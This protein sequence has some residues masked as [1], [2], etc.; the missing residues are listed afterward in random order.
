MLLNVCT[1]GVQ[2]VNKSKAIIIKPLF[3]KTETERPHQSRTHVRERIDQ[4]TMTFAATIPTETTQRTRRRA[5]SLHGAPL[6]KMSLHGVSAMAVAAAMLFGVANTAHAQEEDSKPATPKLTDAVKLEL[7]GKATAIVGVVEGGDARG[8]FDAQVELK[9][10]TVLE[11]GL[12]LGAVI[13]GRYDEDQPGQLFSAGRRSGFLTGGPRG[14]GPLDGNTFVQGAFGYARGGF[15]KVVL[16]RDQG[17]AR[18]FAVTAPTIFES[19]NINDWRTDLTGLNDIH[20]INDFSGYSTKISYLPPANL[21]GGVVGGL[22]LGVS[23][24]PQLTDCGETLCAPQDSRLLLP[25]TALLNE[26][27]RWENVL[28]G[29]FF[30]QK[31]LDFGSDGQKDVFV[32]FGASVV[33]AEEDTNTALGLF[34][35][36]QSYSLGLNV[37]FRGLT[38]GGSV[39]STNGGLLLNDISEDEYFAF[40][41]GVTYKTGDWGFML[42]YGKSESNLIGPTR[43]DSNDTSL[44]RDTQSA[45][46]GVTYFLGRGITIGAAAQYVDSKTPSVIGGPEDAVTAVIETGIRF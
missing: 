30:Y 5:V 38:L 44:F 15:G 28:E 12:E 34:D 27:S 43:V 9:A 24:A 25:D 31:G 6:S 45:Q 33:T 23:Y 10:S 46:A 8:D 11:N 19:I 37:A 36:Y 35:D 4:T 21:L 1:A 39:K 17:V 14:L 18:Q 22:Q 7:S 13:Q 40:D 20:T 2:I 3:S 32:G 29:A 26:T 41:A 16:G 42:G